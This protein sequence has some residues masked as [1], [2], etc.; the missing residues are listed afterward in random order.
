MQ[1]GDGR[2]EAGGDE[3]LERGQHAAVD[4]AG[5]DV[6]A[7]AVVDLD[8]RVGEHALDQ[9]LL[10]HQQDLADRRASRRRGRRTGS[11]P[12]RGRSR[13]TRAASSRRG[14]ASGRSRG[15][16]RPAGRISKRTNGCLRRGGGAD[17]AEHGAGGHL[18]ADL[19]LL[20]DDL[21][22][23]EAERE[24]GRERAVDA[25]GAQ[26]LLL[27]AA[28][29][30]RV[31]ARRVREQALLG[32]RRAAALRRSRARPSST[33]PRASLRGRLRARAVG[34]RRGLAS[35]SASGLGSASMRLTSAGSTFCGFGAA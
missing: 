24:G 6:L 8:A 34:V 33:R 2:V 23:G 15:A 13:S 29:G 3:E 4:R 27:G 18:R 16:P 20:D 17:A 31:R 26:E 1:R 35:A 19:E 5:L 30:H 12:W 7:A 9:R 21:V 25:A 28:G 22:A 11:C 10:A 32:Q 14:S